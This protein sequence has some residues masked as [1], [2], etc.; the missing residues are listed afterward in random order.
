MAWFKVDDRLYS[1]PKWLATP[2]SARGLWVT[3]GS[4]VADHEQDGVIPRHA[5]GLFGHRT[6][7]AQALVEAGLWREVEGGWKFN[8]WTEYQPTSA[9]LS[10]KRAARAAAGRLGGL[11]SGQSRRE[12]SASAKASPDA[13]HGAKQK[14]TPTRPDPS[15]SK[16]VDMGAPKRATQLPKK[17][18][19]TKEHYE[20]AKNAR[21]NLESETEKFRN[22]AIEKGRTS[23]NWN[24]AFT[25]WLIKASEY[26]ANSNT[27]QGR[28]S[29]AANDR[30]DLARRNLAKA[31]GE[32]Q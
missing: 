31:R 8:N 1:H 29:D 22:H 23:K 12:A 18:T 20:R 7:D 11:A 25:N 10:Q 32:N 28:A 21:L 4:W 19:P 3:A 24:L 5:L 6:R 15:P 9:E 26:G 30:W 16:E 27:P 13:S 17:W 2:P 14:G